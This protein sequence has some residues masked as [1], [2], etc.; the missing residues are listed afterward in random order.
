MPRIAKPKIG[1]PAISNRQ[2]KL[3][4]KIS[5]EKYR[6]NKFALKALISKDLAKRIMEFKELKGFTYEEL[7]EYFLSKEGVR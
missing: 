4:R 3:N 5:V 2:K 1:R 7:L 6:E